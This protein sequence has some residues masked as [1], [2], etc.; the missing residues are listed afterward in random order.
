MATFSRGGLELAYDDIQ[1]GGTAGTMLLVHGFAT[2]R[3][4][5]W[6]RLGWYGAFERKGWRTV[7]LDLRGHGQSA[8]PHDPGAYGGEALL[9]DIVGLLDHLDLGR[10]DVMGYSMGA[11][12]ALQLAIQHGARVGNLIA[13]GVGARLLETEPPANAPT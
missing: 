5:N 9:A 3:S 2:N 6:R 7:A 13:G 10:V 4:E 11:R 1:P 12:L 8:K